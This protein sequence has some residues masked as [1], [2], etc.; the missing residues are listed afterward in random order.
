MS[1]YKLIGSY[2]DNAVNMKKTGN[3]VIAQIPLKNESEH[4]IYID[5]ILND[6]RKKEI[7]PT[8]DGFDIIE[9]AI[10]VYLADTRISR[11]KHAEDSW[12]REIAIELPVFNLNIWTSVKNLFSQ[13]LNFLTGDRWE[14]EFVKRENV[15]SENKERKTSYDAVSLFSGGMDSLIGTINHLE[16]N[17][18]I[19]LVSHAGDGYTKDAQKALL[20]EFK[21]RYSDITPTYFNLWLSFGKDMLLDGD[22]ENST[23]SRS[24]LFISF[25]IFI[26]SG[27]KDNKN[28]DIKL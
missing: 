23:R 15:L 26:L 1:K 9:L 19:A 12:T 21:N 16:Q 4:L 28:N 11:I 3:T 22:I 27:L 18:K 6:L 14:I 25:G 2:D 24:F 20:A 5:N 13:M 17:H 8:E 7:Y 10:L